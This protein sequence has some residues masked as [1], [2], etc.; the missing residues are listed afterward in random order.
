MLKRILQFSFFILSAILA[1]TW[2]WSFIYSLPPL[3]SQFNLILIAAIFALFFF[4]FRW[5][6][7]FAVSGGLWL[8][9]VSFNFFGLY[10]ISLVITVFLAE[11]LLSGWLTNRSLYSFSLLIL[12]ASVFYSL[13]SGG[14]SYFFA[15][16]PGIFFF[17]RSSFWWSLIYQAAWSV[18]AALVMFNFAGAATSRLK[19]FFLANK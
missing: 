13:L 12:V 3:A 8:D 2:Q 4:D 7:L 10:T 17:G 18:A 11:R 9:L 19:P 16:E 15:S 5:A 1:A 6:I 14:A